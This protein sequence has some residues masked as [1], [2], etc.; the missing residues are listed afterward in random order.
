M[1]EK[2]RVST[3]G[4][5]RTTWIQNPLFA[6]EY[7]AVTLEL[8]VHLAGGQNRSEAWC[9]VFETGYPDA[10]ISCESTY[11]TDS[12]DLAQVTE[13][14]ADCLRAAQKHLTPFPPAS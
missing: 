9:S 13:W 1:S 8:S 2:R 5:H 7:N 10:L 11:I 14:V 12:H 4:R 3:I 6:R